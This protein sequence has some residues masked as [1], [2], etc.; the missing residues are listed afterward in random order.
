[1]NPK[2]PHLFLP[3]VGLALLLAPL[4]CKKPDQAAARTDAPVS[5]T[6]AAAS[7]KSV[8]RSVEVVGTLFGDEDVTISAKVPGRISDIFVDMGDRIVGG[9][10]LAQ[11]EKTDYDL[12]IRQKTLAVK[13]QLGKLGLTDMPDDDFD[14]INVPTIQRAKLQAEN[15]E[16]K[17]NRAKEANKEGSQAMSQMA[18]D[19]MKNDWDVA[20]RSYD[21]EVLTARASLTAARSL[22]AQLDIGR[23]A[24]SDTTIVAPMSTPPKNFAVS[25]R[26]TSVGEYV[27]EGAGLFHLVADDD[28][29][30]RAMVP[31]RH[32][33]EIALGQ[34]VELSVDSY[35]RT[36]DG[37]VSR[38]NPQIDTQNRTFQ[39]EVL[40]PNREH[41][42]K[43]GAFAKAHVQ[44]RLDAKVIFIPQESVISF[45]GTYKVFTVNDGK[46][47][48]KIV[49][50]GDRQGELVE[51]IKGLDGTESIVVDGA[52]K[53]A[54][55]VSVAPRESTPRE[56]AGPPADSSANATAIKS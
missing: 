41:L 36:F 23:R 54:T 12:A 32:M 34:T 38:I 51:V 21:V 10:P 28:L 47:V 46:A 39:I 35:D 8:Q 16:A 14:P 24:L 55:G 29:K 4:A 6:L 49:E 50:T 3:L 22:A 48:E 44:T 5:I 37:K 26:L 25:Q 52:S 45:A 42:L 1:M 11:I 27:K 7:I 18:V 33:S 2:C 56:T 53:L 13:E 20:K 17:Y 9:K 19:D 40:V 43:P 31:E 30:L 15:A